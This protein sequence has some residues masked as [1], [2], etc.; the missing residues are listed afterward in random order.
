MKNTKLLFMCSLLALSCAC[1][2]Q[3]EPEEIPTVIQTIEVKAKPAIKHPLGIIG[4]VEPVYI[5]PSTTAF[6]ARIDTGAETSSLDVD[7]YHIFERDGVKWVSFKIT[8]NLTGK[9][10]TY[11]K[12]R[13]RRISVRRVN[14]NESRPSVMLDIKFGGKIIKAEFTL[15]KREKFDYQVLIGRNVLTGRAIVD[16]SLSNTLR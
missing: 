15:A 1:K 11:E 12:K 13:H 2:S 3:P 8:N 9:T 4:A 7:E 14:K 6:Q 16:T 5:L 10:E